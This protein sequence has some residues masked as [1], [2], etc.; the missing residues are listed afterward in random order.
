MPVAREVFGGS[1]PG[2]GLHAPSSVA[3]R[4][5]LGSSPSSTGSREAQHMALDAEDDWRCAGCG[6]M[7]FAWDEAHRTWRCTSCQ[8]TSFVQEFDDPAEPWLDDPS[9]LPWMHEPNLQA[10][11]G[12]AATTS[13]TCPTPWPTSLPGRLHHG[14]Y[15]VFQVPELGQHGL[16]VHGCAGALHPDPHGLPVHGIQNDERHQGQQEPPAQQG[17]QRPTGPC[18]FLFPRAFRGDPADHQ[19]PGPH[20]PDLGP[21]GPHGR[22]GA[23]SETSTYDP[24][25]T[26][27]SR[28]PSA[29]GRAFA[30]HAI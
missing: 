14:P 21:P 25:V 16:P 10:A 12:F 29:A 30:Q 28:P 27:P 5:S 4:P 1:A 17:Q 7:N 15:G 18:S 11:P 3:W 22:E 20:P 26:V 19:A 23:E 9:D 13:S 2:P 6:S 8:S 24:T